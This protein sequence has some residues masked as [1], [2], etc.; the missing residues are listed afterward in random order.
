MESVS[1]EDIKM[2]DKAVEEERKFGVGVVQQDGDSIKSF[3][4]P[5]K[6]Y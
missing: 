6:P 4:A 3:D 5:L 1:F 2:N